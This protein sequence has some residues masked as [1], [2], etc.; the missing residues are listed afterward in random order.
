MNLY[1]ISL[2]MRN[3]LEEK[4]KQLELSFIEEDHIYYMRDLNGEIKSNF[5]SVSKLISKF[6]KHFDSEG[7]ALQ[8][9]KGDPEGA[10]ELL[11]EWKQ[12]GDL[13]T[14]MGSRVHFELET[15]TID[16]F[17]NYKNVRQ[18]IFDINEEQQRKSDAMIGAGKE[19][20]D[21]MLERGGV[22]LDTEMV[23]GDPEEGYTGQPDKVWLMM[24]RQKTD[25]G[26]VITDWKTNKPKNFEVQYY[27]GRLYPP[28]GNYH[29]NA[30]GHY[31]LQLPLYGRLILKMLQGTKFDKTKLMG[32]VIVL[33]KENGTFEEFRVPKEI[34]DTILTMDLKK[35]L[36]R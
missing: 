24:N 21:L 14:N 34:S 18:P 11:A 33:L 26:L 1:D 27:T 2:E 22:L 8:M 25:Y 6:H 4:R 10:K 36:K 15:D 29:D 7:K 5:P 30:L 23:L 13:S 12:A 9:C 20:L 16:R 32:S 19:F 28:F 3:A 35:Y 31:Y 17:G